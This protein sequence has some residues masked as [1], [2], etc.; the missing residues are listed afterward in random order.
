MA[1][2]FVKYCE[3]LRNLMREHK[4]EVLTTSEINRL[5]RENYP[6]LD[7]RFMQPSDHCIVKAQEGS[8]DRC[9]GTPN[10]IFEKLEWGKYRVL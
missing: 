7:I 5:F 10:A 4:G 1:E 9:S 2:A 3:E 6:E 8:C